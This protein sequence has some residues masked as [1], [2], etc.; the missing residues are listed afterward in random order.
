MATV[1]AN[2]PPAEPA[3]HPTPLPAVLRRRPWLAPVGVGAVVAAGLAY[4]AWQDPNADGV[5]PQCP[6]FTLFGVD[7]PGCGGLRAVHAAT[8]GHLVATADHNLLLAVALPVLALLWL[9]WLLQT[10]GISVPRLPRV[11]RPAWIG[12]AVVALAF[13]VIRNVGGVGLFEYLAA[14]A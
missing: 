11:A 7:C 6:T 13:T 2:A 5:F 4:T 9:R 8:H 10:L 1:T 12:L 14:T 3:P